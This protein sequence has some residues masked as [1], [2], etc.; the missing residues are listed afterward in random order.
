[1]AVWKLVQKL[2]GKP[3]PTSKREDWG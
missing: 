1:M 3:C 2:S